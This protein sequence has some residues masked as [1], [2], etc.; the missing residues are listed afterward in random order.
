MG[1]FLGNRS[2]GEIWKCQWLSL[3]YANFMRHIESNLRSYHLEGEGG[4]MTYPP[5]S[6]SP[7]FATC[8]KLAECIYVVSLEK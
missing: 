3:G 6:T 1:Y 2:T 4:S 5:T 8:G 7:Y